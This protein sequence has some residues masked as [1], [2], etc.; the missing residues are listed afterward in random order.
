MSIHPARIWNPSGLSA[1]AAFV[2]VAGVML[3]SPAVLAA[4]AGLLGLAVTGSGLAAFMRRFQV[5]PQPAAR[6]ARRR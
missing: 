3:G 4:S 2:F 6:G 1:G 5:R